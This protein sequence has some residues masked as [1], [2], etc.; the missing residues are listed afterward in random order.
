MFD[1][2]EFE[3]LFQHEIKVVSYLLRFR[4][5]KRKDKKIKK[6]SFINL[7]EKGIINE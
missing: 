3:I 7:K 6:L 1:K 2:K 5:K 4:V